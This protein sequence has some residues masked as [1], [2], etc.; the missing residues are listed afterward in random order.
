MTDTYHDKSSDL[1]DASTPHHDRQDP[2]REAVST[3]RR[4][5]LGKLAYASPV[6]A[7]LLFAQSGVNAQTSLGEIPPPAPPG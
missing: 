3:G 6:L 5:A 1:D 4:A 2:G 7:G